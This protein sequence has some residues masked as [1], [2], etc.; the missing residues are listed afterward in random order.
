[1]ANI[2]QSNFTHTYAGQEFLT[3]LYYEPQIT[4]GIDPYSEFQVFPNV[5][6]KTNIYL[7][8]RLQKII[9]VDSGCGF[10]ASGAANIDDK[11]ITVSKLKINTEMCESEFDSTI[12]AELRKRGVARED[13]RDTI[14]EDIIETVTMN[15]MKEDLKKQMWF[16]DSASA[17]TFY[18]IY[19]GY[20]RLFLD[21][22]GTLG[23]AKDMS[24][25]TGAL[26]S[27]SIHE[28]DGALKILRDMYENQSVYLRM[29]PARNKRFMVT[30]T[31][32]DSLL[33]TYQNTGTDSGLSLLQSGAGSLSFNGIPVIDMVEWTPALADSDNPVTTTIEDGHLVILSLPENFAVATDVTSPESEFISWFDLKDEKL[34]TKAKWMHGVEYI[35]DEYVSIAFS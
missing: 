29:V 3:T 23:Y 1:M 8:Q 14:I 13:I 21:A 34:Y 17:D 5:T 10:S 20:V 19:D 26:N 22:S 33:K 11:T 31:V 24:N 2:I 18:G 16:S 32:Y 15:A 35:H 7:P 27:T 9:K 12:F 4:E 6:S 28:T 30:S 25:I